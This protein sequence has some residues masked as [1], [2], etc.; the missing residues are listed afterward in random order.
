MFSE[1]TR[2]TCPNSK[3][4]PTICINM[5]FFQTWQQSV[6]YYSIWKEGPNL[7]TWHYE[8]WRAIFLLAVSSSLILIVWILEHRKQGI[9]AKSLREFFESRAS[10][11]TYNWC[12]GSLAIFLSALSNDTLKAK[13]TALRPQGSWLLAI[14]HSHLS[15]AP[16]NRYLAE[17]HHC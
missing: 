15:S 11:S 3:W 16:L 5:P 8:L 4:A 12:Y 6:H 9:V 7:A 17:L 13:R 14:V 10:I 2:A 1:K